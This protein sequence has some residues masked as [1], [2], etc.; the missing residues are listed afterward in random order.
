MYVIY[1]RCYEEK[2]SN[3]KGYH[4]HHSFRISDFAYT[5][6]LGSCRQIYKTKMVVEIYW[7]HISE[8][9]VYKNRPFHLDIVSS[10]TLFSN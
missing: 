7:K 3:P 10:N 1:P 6:R 2:P 5:C 4:T 8:D 9:S